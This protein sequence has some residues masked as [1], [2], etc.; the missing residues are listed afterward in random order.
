LLEDVS[1]GPGHVILKHVEIFARLAL[2]LLPIN[3][4]LVIGP[5]PADFDRLFLVSDEL[6]EE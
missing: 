1:L 3:V 2:P 4:D 5:P 6:A